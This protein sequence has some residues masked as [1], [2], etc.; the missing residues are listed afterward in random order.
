MFNRSMHSFLSSMEETMLTMIL[1]CS[2]LSRTSVLSPL[3]KTRHDCSNLP[4]PVR[5]DGS[6]ASSAD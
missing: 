5:K 1:E 2:S 4:L 6:E 3:L